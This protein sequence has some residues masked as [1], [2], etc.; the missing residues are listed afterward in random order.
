MK[1][2]KL[3]KKEKDFL[4]AFAKDNSACET[5]IG[6]LLAN[7]SSFQTVKTLRK[8]LPELTVK[9]IGGLLSSL[10]TKGILVLEKG[11]GPYYTGKKS[12]AFKRLSFQPDTYSIA[13]EFLETL[14][15]DETFE[16]AFGNL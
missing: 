13:D 5:L 15:E 8:L 2:F 9:T 1:H 12:D 7:N 16:Q 6:G 10:W 11:D 4:I 3:T 14:D